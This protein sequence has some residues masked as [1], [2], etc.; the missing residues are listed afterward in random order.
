V[1]GSD[2]HAL[3]SAGSVWTEVRGA[4]TKVEFLE[5]LCEG[6]A[7]VRG[8]SGNYWKLTGD[9]LAVSREMFREKPFMLLLAP[10]LLGI[11]TVTLINYFS[12]RRF[13]RKWGQAWARMRGL[14]GGQSVRHIPAA[15][16]EATA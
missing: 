1:G 11:P 10:L 12:E 4:R 9:V 15:T 3:A 14:D 2:A 13:A 7:R 6:R 16:G 8:E 5:G